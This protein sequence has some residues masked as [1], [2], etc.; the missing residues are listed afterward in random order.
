MV[1]RWAASGL[2]WAEAGF[3]KVRGHRDLS[4]LEAALTVDGAARP[5]PPQAVVSLTTPAVASADA[6]EET[7]LKG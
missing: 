7:T 6:G 3:R 1:S 2:L 4:E 5:E